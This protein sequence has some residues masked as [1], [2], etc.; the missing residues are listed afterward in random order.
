M[1]GAVDRTSFGSPESTQSGH[2]LLARAGERRKL[3]S[4]LLDEIP[5]TVSTV[6]VSSEDFSLPRADAGESLGRFSAFGR[7]QIV[8]VLRRQDAWIESYYKHVVDQ[9]RMS[10]TRSFDEFLGQMGPRLLD[11]HARFSPWRELVG[12]ESFH[13]LSYD[14]LESAEAVC[15]RVLEIAGVRGSIVDDPESIPV[16]RYAGVRAIDT[17]GMRI[18]NAYR[19]DDRNE[20]A[21]I[22]KSIYAAAPEGD[23]ELMTPEMRDGIQTLCAPINERIEAEWFRQPVPGFRFGAPLDGSAEGRP[24]GQDVVDYVDQVI[25]LCEGARRSAGESGSAE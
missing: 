21:R 11:F 13:V 20:R 15:R 16:P 25:S 14:D 18:V 10:E 7:V 2:A 1:T 5:E 23:I 8:L 24:S 6:L 22:A 17:L 12:P 9:H 19:L 3:V 4:E